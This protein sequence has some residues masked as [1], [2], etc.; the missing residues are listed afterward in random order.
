MGL[1]VIE[2]DG[3]EDIFENQVIHKKRPMGFDSYGRFFVYIEKF[4][5]F[6]VQTPTSG[7]THTG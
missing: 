7:I 3:G 6:F 2:D 1:W 5:K 4:L